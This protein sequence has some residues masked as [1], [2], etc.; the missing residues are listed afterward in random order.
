MPETGFRWSGIKAHLRKWIGLYLAA[1][2]AL[3]LFNHLVYTVT[4][5]RPSEAETL[6]IM[7]ANVEFTP[8][9]EALLQRIQAV[10]E[11][12]RALALE[13]LP[14][15]DE[16]DPSSVMLF[17]AKLIGGT[18]DVFITDEAGFALLEKRGA[19][20]E[21]I[22]SGEILVTAVTQEAKAFLP[23]ITEE[24]KGVQE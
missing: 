15:A 20:A 13:Y 16:S 4:R 14:H 11:N 19:V 8:D 23:A 17:T 2:L 18:G 21:Y 1:T 9:E 22:R 12:I 5:P 6:R 24:I 10:D 7:A 3:C